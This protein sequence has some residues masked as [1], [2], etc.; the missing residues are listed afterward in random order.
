MKRAIEELLEAIW[1]ADEEQATTLDDIR[2][3]CPM[4]VT[5]DYLETLGLG[6]DCPHDAEP[7]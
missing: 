4:D 3:H 2:R 5:E 1:K 7:A 6:L